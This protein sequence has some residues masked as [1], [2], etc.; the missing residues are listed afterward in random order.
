MVDNKQRYG[1]LTSG[2]RTFFLFLDGN[3][4]E[5]EVNVSEPYYVGE[6]IYLRAWS[7]IVSLGAAQKGKFV[8]PPGWLKTDSQ[9]L[10]PDGKDEGNSGGEEQRG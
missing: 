9:H 3:G 10:T 8:A 2:T 5:M 4:K 1:V 6:E 7:Y